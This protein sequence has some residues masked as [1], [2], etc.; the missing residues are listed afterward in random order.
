MLR[1]RQSN[2]I[3]HTEMVDEMFGYLKDLEEDQQYA[4]YDTSIPQMEAQEDISE[5]KFSKFAATY[6]QVCLFVEL[7]T[8]YLNPTFSL[9]TQNVNRF[10]VTCAIIVWYKV[11]F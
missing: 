3:D 8:L 7:L 1:Q 5:Y 9:L 4:N 10:S 6:F 11:K 2:A